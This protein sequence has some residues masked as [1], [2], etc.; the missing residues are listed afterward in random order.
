MI[1]SRLASKPSSAWLSGLVMAILLAL[2]S[3]VAPANSDQRAAESADSHYAAGEYRKA[4]RQYLR[5]ARK[6]D[7][8]SQYRA[9]YMHLM[10]EGVE[11]DYP[12]AFAWAVLAAESGS[13]QLETYLEEVK[14]QVPTGQ[15]EAAQRKAEAYLRE[16]GRLA[17]AI[18]ARRKAD[19][20][21]RSCTG[22]RLG[23]RC[24]EVYA[25]EMPKFWSINPGAGDGSDGGSAAPSGSVSGAGYG[26]GGATRDAEHYQELREY[27]AELDRMIEQESGTVELGA[28]EVL[29]PEAKS[30]DEETGSRD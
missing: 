25:V 19:R 13:P 20:Q 24:D 12:T 21:M 18:E 9:S 7:P 28:F 22:S 16:W 3:G 5:L 29:E 8:F 1:H 23:T 2:T 11:Q 27:A 17:L 6:G 14:A 30:E 10:G 26:A 4:Y 15:R